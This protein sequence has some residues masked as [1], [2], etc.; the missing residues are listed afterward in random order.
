VVLRVRDDL[1]HV[2]HRQ[3]GPAE[4][5][6]LY[7]AT[8]HRVIAEALGPHLVEDRPVALELPHEDANPYQV[9]QAGAGSGEDRFRPDPL[10]CRAGSWRRGQEPTGMRS[11]WHF[12]CW[13]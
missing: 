3:P 4:V 6:H 11:T 8:G 13:S 12:R 7:D 10:H 1:D 2:A 5:S 9:G